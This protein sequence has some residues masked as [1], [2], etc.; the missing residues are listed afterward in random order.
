MTCDFQTVKLDSRSLGTNIEL[1]PHR[2]PLQIIQHFHANR[3]NWSN[4][5]AILYNACIHVFLNCCTS[6]L[7]NQCYATSCGGK[8]TSD[9]TCFR[10]HIQNISMSY[11]HR[12]KASHYCYVIKYIWHVQSKVL[13]MDFAGNNIGNF[14]CLTIQTYF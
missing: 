5:L 7:W 12:Q 9:N 14:F 3:K 1:W 6:I 10:H 13:I 11:N 2:Q 8:V 4:F